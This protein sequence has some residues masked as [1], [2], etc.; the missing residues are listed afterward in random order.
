MNPKSPARPQP[1]AHF[2]PASQP[3]ESKNDKDLMMLCQ[4]HRR[5]CINIVTNTQTRSLTQ[6]QKDFH[7]LSG[8]VKALIEFLQDPSKKDPSNYWSDVEDYLVRKLDFSKPFEG[9][10]EYQILL[11]S[12]S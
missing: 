11:Q 2:Q 3:Q 12:K 10:Q 1:Q 5:L 8:D 7:A 4:I 6:V 9:Q